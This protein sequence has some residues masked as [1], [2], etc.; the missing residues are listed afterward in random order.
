MVQLVQLDGHA[1][2][3]NVSV[4]HCCVLIVFERMRLIAVDKNMAIIHCTICVGDIKVW[5]K[6]MN[7][8]WL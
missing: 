2:V 1:R 4:K 3:S 8:N 5:A 6:N 7:F